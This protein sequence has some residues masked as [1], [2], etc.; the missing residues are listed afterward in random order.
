M[1]IST[2]D[3][4]EI[5]RE[6]VFFRSLFPDLRV[7]KEW[8]RRGVEE[9]RWIHIST[10]FRLDERL[11][12]TS[13]FPNNEEELNIL[14]LL[15]IPLACDLLSLGACDLGNPYTSVSPYWLGFAELFLTQGVGALLVSRWSLDDLG[16]DI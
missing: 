13:G 16:S 10:H 5:R 15:Q 14:R 9:A 2:P 12:P 11:W 1:P 8:E 4:P 3:L 6:E 7:V